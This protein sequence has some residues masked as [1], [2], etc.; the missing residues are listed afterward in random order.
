MKR[1][2]SDNFEGLKID[3]HCKYT[4]MKNTF[5]FSRRQRFPRKGHRETH[6]RVDSATSEQL[7]PVCVEL[8][9][10]LR[11][12]GVLGGSE[13]KGQLVTNVPKSC[14]GSDGSTLTKYPRRPCS[15]PPYVS[16]DQEYLPNVV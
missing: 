15:T 13:V 7:A 6:R 12:F 8:P 4:S 16:L 2:W 3:P 1:Q 9:T 10:H 11:Q 5:I 14:V